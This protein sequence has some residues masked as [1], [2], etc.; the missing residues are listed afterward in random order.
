[1]NTGPAAATANDDK[2]WEQAAKDRAAGKAATAPASET[3]P[4][5]AS[6]ND[7]TPKPQDAAV[8]PTPTPTPAPTPTPTPTPSSSAT[9]PADDP[10]AGLPEPTRKLIQGLQAADTRRQQEMET[11]QHQLSTAHG[12]IGNLKQRLD[13]SHQKITTI[14][15]VLDAVDAD[16]KAAAQRVAVEK[17]AKVKAAREKLA[18]D[19]P[20][21]AEILD[22]LLPEETATPAPTPSAAATTPTPTPTPT[23]AP[24]PTPTPTPAPAP[25]GGPTTEQVLIAQRELSDLHPGW[26]KTRATPEFRDWFAAQPDQ[27]KALAGSWQ[28]ADTSKVFDAFKKHQSDAALVAQ[29]EKERQERLR[30]GE[31]PQGRGSATPGAPSSDDALWDQAKRDRDKA[32]IATA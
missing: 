29:T 3:T 28:V 24:T 26:M 7:G 27:V 5:P 31:G 23:P 21:V 25:T 17:Q 16:R 4:A 9:P 11:M 19:L 30:R 32:K 1:M 14:T 10:L 13:E 22:L 8:T 20:E 12:T 18:T 6:A 2:L 15:P